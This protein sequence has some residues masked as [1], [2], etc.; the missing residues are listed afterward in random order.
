MPRPAELQLKDRRKCCVQTGQ[1][2]VQIKRKAA[3]D[4]GARTIA[5]SI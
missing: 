1:L 2:V 3:L 4:L 5:R